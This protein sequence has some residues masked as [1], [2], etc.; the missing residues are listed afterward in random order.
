MEKLTVEQLLE[1]T[2]QVEPGLELIEGKVIVKVS[3]DLDMFTAAERE[4]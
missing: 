1:N 2:G 4:V 3:N